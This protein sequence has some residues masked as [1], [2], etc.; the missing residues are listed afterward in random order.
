MN[1]QCRRKVWVS[2]CGD[3]KRLSY[4]VSRL[5][6]VCREMQE[7]LISLW[8]MVVDSEGDEVGSLKMNEG[9]T[10]DCVRA[11]FL[12]WQVIRTRDFPP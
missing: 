6:I 12:F 9:W 7:A 3:E 11:H 4:L 5:V 2:R 8:A 10:A 1:T